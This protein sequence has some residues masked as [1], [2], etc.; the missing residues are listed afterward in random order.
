[1]ITKQYLMIRNHNFDKDGNDSLHSFMPSDNEQ[2]L[3]IYAKWKE[4]ALSRSKLYYEDRTS[5][6]FS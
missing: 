1:M 6:G 4:W 2:L 3:V 5:K